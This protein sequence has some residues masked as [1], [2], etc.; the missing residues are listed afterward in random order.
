MLHADPSTHER[1]AAAQR[2]PGQPPDPGGCVTRTF[3]LVLFPREMQGEVVETL[4]E[5]GL[6]GYTELAKVTG[7]G[8]RG[9]HFDTPVWPGAEGS[10]FTVGPQDGVRLRAAMARLS[11]DLE[12]RSRGLYGLHLFAWS[13]EHVL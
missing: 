8:P 3:Y 2:L 1:P 13:C 12:V 5:L 11:N 10:I 4:E 9:R 6:P 7:R